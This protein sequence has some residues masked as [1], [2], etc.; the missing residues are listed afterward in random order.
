MSKRATNKSRG[1][2][3]HWV[4]RTRSGSHAMAE[5][6]ALGFTR[7]LAPH[8]R[9]EFCSLKSRSK[10][11]L[12][13]GRHPPPDMSISLGC[14]GTELPVARCNGRPSANFLRIRG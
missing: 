14:N 2:L 13:G 5:K 11:Q 8:P 3:H 10:R 7:R 1:V 6:E 12:H 9:S 4:R